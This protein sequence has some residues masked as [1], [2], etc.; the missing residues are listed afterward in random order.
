M[1]PLAPPVPTSEF[2]EK[3]L[4]QLERLPYWDR[5]LFIKRHMPGQYPRF[6]Y[7]YASLN[8]DDKAS[9][10]RI[11]DMIVESCFWLS[12]HERF[13]DPFDLTANIVLA[14][15]TSQRRKRF[16]ALIANQ[17]NLP[18]KERRAL[19]DKFMARPPAEWEASVRAIFAD[20]A[21]KVGVCSFA[22]EPLSILMWAH[23]GH[24]H[25]GL[26]L[27]FEFTLDPRTF[28]LAQPINYTDKYPMLNY[29][30]GLEREIVVPLTS[31]YS[32]WNY[33][34]EWRILHITGADC[35][36]HFNPRALRRIVLG[37]RAPEK[38]RL[39]LATL[40]DARRLRGF[41]EIRLYRAE[42][43]KTAYKLIA[44]R[45]STPSA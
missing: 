4:G 19:L 20:T 41:P 33:E 15:T 18:H 24:Y 3:V 13:N 27:Q 40:L 22:G 9:V 25:E 42:M 16:K 34:K 2:S 21:K 39:S 26:C 8:P 29:L 44:R 10:D 28:A 11:R 31:K 17:S 1:G 7:K 37:C 30:Q 45:L 23:Y 6:F 36:L 43:H 5:R 14:G 12:N 32:G 38:V 35:S